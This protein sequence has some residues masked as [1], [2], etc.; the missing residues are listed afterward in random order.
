MKCGRKKRKEGRKALNQKRKGR[1]GKGESDC[2]ISAVWTRRGEI[3]MSKKKK[4][5]GDGGGGKRQI[6]HLDYVVRTARLCILVQ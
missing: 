4:K 5:E 2:A 1:S 6:T 3:L